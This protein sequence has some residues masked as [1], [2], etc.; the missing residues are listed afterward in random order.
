VAGW[1]GQ[2]QVCPWRRDRKK[3]DEMLKNIFTD[4]YTALVFRS[5]LGLIFVYASLD[6]IANPQ[7]FAEIVY[8]YKIL[9]P[10]LINIFALTL[11]WIELICGLFLIGGIFLDSASLVILLLLLMFMVATSINVFIRGIDIQCGCFTTSLAAKKQGAEL[12]IR[13]IILLLMSI[14]V[15][16]FNRNFATLP[17]FYRKIFYRWLLK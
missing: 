1:S 10:F 2:K 5:I 15:F 8:N 16:L 7:N 6:K 17:V 4:K 9:P 11:P 14:Q 13:D 12:M 3:L